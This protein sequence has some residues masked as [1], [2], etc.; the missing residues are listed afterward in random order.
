MLGNL[1]SRDRSYRPCRNF[2]CGKCESVTFHN[3]ANCI[4]II[5]VECQIILPQSVEVHSST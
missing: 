1:Y 4:T 2:E 3:H 5:S